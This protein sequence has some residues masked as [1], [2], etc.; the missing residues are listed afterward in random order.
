M[1]LGLLGT[2]DSQFYIGSMILAIEYLHAQSIIYRDLKPENIMIDDKVKLNINP[3]KVFQGF[4]KLIDMG[5]A[6]FLKSKQGGGNRTFTIIGTPHY[7][8]PEIITGK[9]YTLAVDLWSIGK[10]DNYL[11]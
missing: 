8:A 5:T 6:K 11:Y 2:Y 3:L 10:L 9:G 7:M 4:M 1:M